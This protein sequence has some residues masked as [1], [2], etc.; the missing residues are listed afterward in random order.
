MLPEETREDMNTGAVHPVSGSA[1][2]SVSEAVPGAEAVTETERLSD[3]LDKTDRQIADLICERM[4]ICE[5]IMRINLG[6]GERVGHANSHKEQIGRIV[7]ETQDPF[8]RRG[9]TEV[10]DQLRAMNRKRRYQLLDE[11]G[12]SGRLPFI[13]VDELDTDHVRVVYQGVEGAYSHAAMCQYFGEE[14]NSFHVSSW[15]EAM[16]S[17][18]DGEADYA[19]LPIENS[20]AG[21]VAAN[22]DLLVEFENYIV[23]EQ[24]LPIEHVLM[25][26]PGSGM[27][28]IRRVYSHP[29]ALSQCAAFLREHPEWEIIPYD[30]TATAARKVA[31]EGDPAQAAIASAFAAKRFGLQVLQEHIRTSETN[32]T[33]FLIVTNQ[34]I[35]RKNADKISICFEVP[36]R[37]GSLYSILAHFIYND[38]NMYRIE[39]RPIPGRNWEYRFF[40]DFNGNLS[41]SSVK[42]ALRGIRREAANLKILGCY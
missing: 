41:E 39:S 18:A 42:S 17:I 1:S 4:K 16:E 40:I 9:L 19:V 2:G 31:R 6:S 20:T 30:N 12:A 26:V 33:R 35:F 5:E 15:R 23:A 32:S 25:G 13:A 8:M 22:F 29:Q 38:L 36:H 14:V 28:E 11:Y 21:I 27:D 34:R 7:R 10:F 37:S 24:V 3:R